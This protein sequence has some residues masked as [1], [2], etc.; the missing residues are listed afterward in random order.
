MK[1]N[2]GR[3]VLAQ[4]GGIDYSSR[5]AFSN[6]FTLFSYAISGRNHPFIAVSRALAAFGLERLY[7]ENSYK[8]SIGMISSR[9][10][11]AIPR[12]PWVV[13]DRS[14]YRP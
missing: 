1:E 14:Q 12:A 4:D 10:E 5:L 6:T 3:R 11:Q 7:I 9:Q 8:K 2:E 13:V